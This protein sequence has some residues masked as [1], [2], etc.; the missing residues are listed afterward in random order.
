MATIGL[1]FDKDEAVHVMLQIAQGM[2][3]VHEKNVVH[4]DLK[5]CN[6]LV[7]NSSKSRQLEVKVADFGLSMRM[8][9]STSTS[10]AS[11]VGTIRWMAPEV[12]VDENTS[13]PKY[14]PFKSD[15]YSFGCLWYEILVARVPFF[16]TWN[17]NEVKGDV[18]VQDRPPLLPEWSVPTLNPL[19]ERC[20]QREAIRQ[21]S[22]SEIVK[23][24]STI[25]TK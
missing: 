19:I 24:L 5:S 23:E 8:N 14:D 10:E 12:M 11:M 6:I 2:E 22:F 1:V 18:L 13:K 21:P 20:W 15:V 9:S 7:R 25:S 16:E 17:I 3:Y 4:K